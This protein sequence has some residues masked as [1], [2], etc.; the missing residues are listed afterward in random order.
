MG[1]MSFEKTL[2]NSD[3]EKSQVYVTTRLTWKILKIF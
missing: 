2:G 1:R 3:R